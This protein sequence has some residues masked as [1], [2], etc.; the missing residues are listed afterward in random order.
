MRKKLLLIA[1]MILLSSQACDDKDC[2]DVLCFTPPMP[3]A[4]ELVDKDTGENLFT[5]GSYDSNDIEVLNVSDNSRREFVF[6]SENDLNIIQI[7]SI[8]WDS[9]IAEV[10]L[11]VGDETILNLYVDSERISEDCC[12]FTKY[13]EIRIDNAEYELDQQRGIYTILID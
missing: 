1:V 11:K 3:F 6:I 12:N 7:G 4:F 10:V 9:E 8:G 2:E 5:N 13:N